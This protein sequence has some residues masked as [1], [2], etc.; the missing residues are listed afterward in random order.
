MQYNM[1][2]SY[3]CISGD[4][5]KVGFEDGDGGLVI[6]LN[7]NNETA[8]GLSAGGHKNGTNKNTGTALDGGGAH[9]GTPFVFYLIIEKFSL[10]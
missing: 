7:P 3:N 1:Y 10:I 4:P 8:G 9:N 6:A 2:F 5:S